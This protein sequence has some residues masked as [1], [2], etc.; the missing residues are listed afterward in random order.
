MAINVAITQGGLT[1]G[2][3]ADHLLEV[4]LT[5]PSALSLARICLPKNAGQVVVFLLVGAAQNIVH[6]IMPVSVLLHKLLAPLLDSVALQ[7]LCSRL[8]HYH[9]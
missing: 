3:R 4:R 6:Y 5:P 8:L 7:S 1:C 9:L 2:A